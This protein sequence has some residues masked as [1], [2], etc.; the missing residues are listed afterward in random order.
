MK[1]I[2]HLKDMDDGSLGMSITFK[3]PSGD[4]S[5]FTRSRQKP[6]TLTD[7]FRLC[8]SNIA[9][10]LWK[11]GL[12]TGHTIEWDEDPSG[13]TNRKIIGLSTYK[14]RVVVNKTD[15][16]DMVYEVLKVDG[17]WTVIKHDAPLMTWDEAVTELKKRI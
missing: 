17:V 10:V 16:S 1:A 9:T 4:K 14:K 3:T 11:N 2:Y 8:K 15:Y 5:F 6:G 13:I 7:L 12:G